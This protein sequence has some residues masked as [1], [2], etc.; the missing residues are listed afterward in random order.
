MP[1]SLLHK[2]AFGF[3]NFCWS[4]AIPWLK[5][6]HR[7]A[8]GYH[9]RT[10]KDK[11]P[12]AADLWIQA[13]S[14]G[15][16][17][18]ALEILKSLR[19]EQPIKVLLTSNTQQGIEILDRQLPRQI[20]NPDQIQ[21]SIRYFPFD[22]PSI[23]AAAVAFI[24]PRLMVLLESEI[25]PGLLLA[26]K[27]QNCRVIV[28]NGRITEKSL[29]RYH[30]WPSIWQNLR[31]DKVLAISLDDASRF[32]RLFGGNEI[33]IMPNIKFDRIDSSQSSQP[34]KHNL[35]TLLPPAVAFVILA[36]VRRQEESLIKKI[37]EEIL[38]KRPQTVFGVFPRHMH[39]LPPWQK[40]LNQAGLKWSLR[41]K[42]EIRA[43]TGSVIL[44]D[45]FGELLP[46][47]RHAKAAFIGGSLA[48]L[49]GQNFLEPLVNGV[50]PVIGPSWENFAWVGSGI[51]ESG[52]LRVAENWSRVANLLLKDID[53]PPRRIDVVTAALRYIN[54]RRGGTKIA[55]R[56]IT[57][58]LQ[59]E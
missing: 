56:H 22:K 10:L 6:N 28:I 7:L 27:T 24:R 3:Y 48:P 21:T 13:A 42:L 2:T 47:Y 51:I 11:R 43:P 15:E 14:V 9:Q 33:E 50:L 29:R 8:Q 26:L 40:M 32:G 1:L 59:S 55:C 49:G 53:S 36:S 5:W 30:L 38:A 54:A 31:P 20:G 44:W 19:V 12:G 58:S 39:R 37:V 57:E 52:L 4:S 18:L 25:W 45:T 16:S 17:F 34:V 41:S 46:A 23:M 35:K